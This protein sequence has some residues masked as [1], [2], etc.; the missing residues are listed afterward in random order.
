MKV[1]L[2]P[3]NL[4]IIINASNYE[5]Q[6]FVNFLNSEHTHLAASTAP[7]RYK[8]CCIAFSK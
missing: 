4:V 6:Y 3:G 5:E 8:K 2:D 7:E 1:Y